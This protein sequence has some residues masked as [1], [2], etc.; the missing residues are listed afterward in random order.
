M[1]ILETLNVDN[2]PTRF[3]PAPDSADWGGCRD[4]NS[5]KNC[6]GELKPVY[7]TEYRLSVISNLRIISSKMTSCLV[8]VI[9]NVVSSWDG[10]EMSG[11][12]NMIWYL[13]IK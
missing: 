1:K 13:A 3:C 5:P 12:N 4:Q 7:Y 11:R 9:H 6:K 8:F 2:E 10:F